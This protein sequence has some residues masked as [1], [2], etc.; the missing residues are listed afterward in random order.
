MDKSLIEST[1]DLDEINGL[2]TSNENNKVN[3]KKKK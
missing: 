2:S 3:S 1:L